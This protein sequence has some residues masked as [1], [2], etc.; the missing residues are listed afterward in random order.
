MS[1]MQF[2]VTV[3]A[4]LSWWARALIWSCTKVAAACFCLIE[5]AMDHG[6][7]AKVTDSE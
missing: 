4:R 5:F 1:K 7:S 3:T 6:I 2:S